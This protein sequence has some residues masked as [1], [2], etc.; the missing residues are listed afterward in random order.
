MLE[1]RDRV[2]NIYLSAVSIS[3]AI[4][5]TGD[6]GAHS[7]RWK[8]WLLSSAT[9]LVSLDLWAIGGSNEYV[10]DL[11]AQ[12]ESALLSMV[13]ITVFHQLVLV[14]P[15]LLQFISRVERF[16]AL[17]RAVLVFCGHLVEAIFSS[18]TETGTVDNLLKISCICRVSDQKPTFL[19]QVCNSALPPSQLSTV[20][21]LH[22]YEWPGLRLPWQDD[23][24]NMQWLELLR[25]FTA[26]KNL[27]LFKELG[28]RVAPALH[29]LVGEKVAEVLPALQNLF[30][31]ELRSSGVVLDIRYLTPTLWSPVAHRQE[32][33]SASEYDSENGLNVGKRVMSVVHP[34]YSLLIP[35]L[36]PL[37]ET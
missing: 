13:E 14:T 6:A 8:I 11:V 3:F 36:L 18:Q 2:C 15:Q 20:E 9:D 21:H 4:G 32:L 25:P 16:K 30:I 29:G 5:G 24:E 33:A 37:L 17:D 28:L 7:L 22:I 12:I 34:I 19:R 23:M 27:H 1:H 35:D 10:E 31:K 26:V